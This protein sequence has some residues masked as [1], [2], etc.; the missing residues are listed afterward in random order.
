MSLSSILCFVFVTG[1]M[2]DLLEDKDH[3][4]INDETDNQR[5]NFLSIPADKNPQTY[6]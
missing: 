5:L 4:F 6:G 2:K 1:M 3:Y